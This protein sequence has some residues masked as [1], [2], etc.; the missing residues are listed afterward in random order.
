[1]LRCAALRVASEWG[2]LSLA[3]LVGGNSHRCKKNV[4]NVFSLSRCFTLLN[5]FFYFPS[6][7]KIKKMKLFVL[8]KTVAIFY[9]VY[10]DITTWLHIA[11]DAICN[12]IVMSV[13]LSEI[14]SRGMRGQKSLW[15]AQASCSGG[16]LQRC[17]HSPRPLTSLARA[18]R[19]QTFPATGI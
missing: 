13:L 19:T 17:S 16:Q 15:A 5:I 12:P 2:S 7:F 10:T 11:K 6:V 9:L 3:P 14:G 8:S 1:M 4:F 18:T